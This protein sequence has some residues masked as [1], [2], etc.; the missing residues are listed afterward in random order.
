VRPFLVPLLAVGA[1]PL[2]IVL[3]GGTLFLLGNPFVGELRHFV[4]ESR[5]LPATLQV[6]GAGAVAGDL[7]SALLLVPAAIFLWRPGEGRLVIGALTAVTAALVLMAFLVVRWWMV[8]SAAQIVL[9]VGLVIVAGRTPRRRRALA[10]T[11]AG[12]L[13][14]A[15]SIW[16]ITRDYRANREAK[17]ADVDL[18]QPLY[19]DLAATLRAT[20]PDGV[21]TLLASPNASAG[22]SY[23]GRFQSIG[24][25]FWENA[26]GLRA[27][28]EMLCAESDDEARRLMRARGVTHVV[29]FSAAPFVGEYFRLLYPNRPAEDARRTLGFRLASGPASAPGWLQAI[30]YRPPAALAGIGGVPWL[31]EVV[32]DQ[33]EDQRLFHTAVAQAASGGVA[34]AEQSFD[35]ALALVPPNAQ[36]SFCG[37]AGE[38]AYEQGADALAVRWL[39]RSLGLRNDP[40]VA[41]LTAWI[42]ATSLEASLRDG[43]AALALVTPLAQ[44]TP[45][46][47]VVL[48]TLAAACAEVGRFEEAASAA[49]RALALVRHAGAEADAVSLLTMRL[50]AYRAGRPWR[51]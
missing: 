5:S 36:A 27:A 34:A 50:D 3:G 12:V 38:A 32:P 10:L 4:V 22:I 29:M 20:N 23:F 13:F 31:F 44:R 17:V 46:D 49:G 6:Y 21:I 11:M 40:N 37:F 9:L 25:L 28:A 14:V 48:S 35:S 43:P 19:R 15:P 42:L 39:R 47:A 18:F 33:S 41:N 30:P 8:A 2:A 7:V 51:Q 1:A 24:T 45:N 26:P 16:R